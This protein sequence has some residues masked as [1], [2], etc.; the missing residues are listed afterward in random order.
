M[1]KDE[2]RRVG[3]GGRGRQGSEGERKN[4]GKR[5]RILSRLQI[6][7]PDEPVYPVRGMRL[8]FF[9]SFLPQGVSSLFLPFLSSPPPLSFS[10]I[11]PLLAAPTVPLFF[12]RPNPRRCPRQEQSKS[13]GLRWV[14]IQDPRVV[15][16]REGE[17][18]GEGLANGP[19]S[20]MIRQD[21]FS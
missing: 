15:I 18:Q 13:H 16:L 20:Q 17:K 4:G 2:W 8:I 10:L 9:D 1:E 6:K 7:G 21:S 19:I 11:W 12:S 5:R 14:Q 3:Y